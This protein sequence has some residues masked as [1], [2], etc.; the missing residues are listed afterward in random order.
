MDYQLFG[1]GSPVYYYHAPVNVACYVERLPRLDGIDGFV[2]IVHGARRIET[3][4]WSR[5]R[6]ARKRVREVG[7]FHCRGEAHP[8]QTAST[9]W[10]SGLLLVGQRKN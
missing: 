8:V 7:Y 10:S 5:R 2:F 9:K 3:A 6:L 1:I 4:N